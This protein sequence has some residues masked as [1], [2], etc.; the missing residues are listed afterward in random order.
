MKHNWYKKLG[1]D[2]SGSSVVKTPHFQCRVGEGSI[3]GRG[4]KIPYAVWHGQIKKKK[5]KKLGDR[6][7]GV[8]FTILF[9]LEYV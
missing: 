7:M 8:H 3:P 5:K 6:H 1:E 4:T 2:F 9:T